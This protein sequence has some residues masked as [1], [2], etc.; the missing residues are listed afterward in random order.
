MLFA[1][2]KYKK[3]LTK[4]ENR[5]QIIEPNDLYNDLNFGNFVF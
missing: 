2:K 3:P 4:Y 5:P 1:R